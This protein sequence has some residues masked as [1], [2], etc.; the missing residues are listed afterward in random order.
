M[1]SSRRPKADELSRRYVSGDDV[2]QDARGLKTLDGASR[3]WR[4]LL[5]VHTLYEL[6]RVEG[7]SARVPYGNSA[8]RLDACV[9]ADNHAVP[10]TVPASVV[11]ASWEDPPMRV[12]PS[13]PDFC[14]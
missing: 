14:F 13:D 8:D 1:A 5:M 9:R 12:Y 2:D 7:I 4:E 11:A 10:E 3:A 6:L